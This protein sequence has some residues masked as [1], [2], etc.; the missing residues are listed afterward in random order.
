MTYDEYLVLQ[1]YVTHWGPTYDY[2]VYIP[3]E[4]DLVEDGVRSSDKHYQKEIDKYIKDILEEHVDPLNMCEI[5]GSPSE[6]A[7]KVKNIIYTLVELGVI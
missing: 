2:I 4:F 6:R 5:R 3:I 1:R 7:T